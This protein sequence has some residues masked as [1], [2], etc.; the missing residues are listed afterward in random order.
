MAPSYNNSQEESRGADR[1]RITT[2]QADHCGAFI[3]EQTEVARKV[4]KE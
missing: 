3:K 2:E 1:P 4:G